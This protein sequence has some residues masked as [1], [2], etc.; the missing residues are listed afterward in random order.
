MTEPGSLKPAAIRLTFIDSLT[1]NI[2]TNKCSF[3]V[4]ITKYPSMKTATSIKIRISGDGAKYSRTSNFN[5][6]LFGILTG[7]NDLSCQSK[8]VEYKY[9]LYAYFIC[10]YTHNSSRQGKGRLQWHCRRLLG[11]FRDNQ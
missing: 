10:S 11:L 4:Q 5:V 8:V 1:E 7:H 9:R 6:M 3:Y 2:C